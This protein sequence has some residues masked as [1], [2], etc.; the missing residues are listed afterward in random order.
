MSNIVEIK[1]ITTADHQHV[2]NGNED[3]LGLHQ[4]HHHHHELNQH[5]GNNDSIT[6]N[7]YAQNQIH[8]YTTSENHADDFNSMFN[9]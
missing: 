6:P 4:H 5:N 1:L 7:Q 9:L 3:E 8:F 2:T